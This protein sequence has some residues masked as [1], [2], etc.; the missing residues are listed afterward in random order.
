MRLRITRAGAAYGRPPPPASMRRRAILTSALGAAAAFILAGNKPLSVTAAG[1]RQESAGPRLADLNPDR[2]WPVY[3]RYHL[4]I[5]GQRDDEQGLAF[6]AA[7]V[8]A[9]A[10]FLPASRAMLV[11]SLLRINRMSAS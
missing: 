2:M 8:D 7:V 4:L 11:C 10:R 6:A 3:R 5:V 1:A 9:L